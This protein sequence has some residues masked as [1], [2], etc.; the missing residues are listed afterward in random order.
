MYADFRDYADVGGAMEPMVPPGSRMATT[1]R[2]VAEAL[3]AERL[4]ELEARRRGLH[5]IGDTGITL[6]AA[7]R[8]RLI[9]V[10]VA[11]TREVGWLRNQTR[12][13]K[14][15]V[16]FF[17]RV[18]PAADPVAWRRRGMPAGPRR[19]ASVQ[20]PDVRAYLRWL[21]GLS[22]GRGG[23]LSQGSLRHHLSALSGVYEWAIS[24][25]HLPLGSN[26]V[27]AL[28]DKPQVPESETPLREPDEI[29]LLLE[30]ARLFD[31]DEIGV[32]GARARVLDCVHPLLAFFLYTGARED[33]VR[34][35]DVRDVHF[36]GPLGPW[37]EIR[38]ANKGRKRRRIQLLR[39]VPMCTHLEEILRAHIRT[40]DRLSGPL[41][42]ARDGKPFGDWRG[43]LD[44]VA[45]RAGYEAGQIRTR[46]F[47]TAYG[48]HR[49][50]CD[51]V[52]PNTVRLEMGHTSLEQLAETY[53]LTQ[54]RSERMG[55]E[56]DY[57][58]ERW[59]HRI[60][61]DRLERLQAPVPRGTVQPNAQRVSV[62]RQFLAAVQGM[63]PGEVKARTGVDDA[64]FYRLRTG[65]QQD[66][67]GKTLER[68]RAFLD[69][70]EE[71]SG[72]A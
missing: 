49:L 65:K 56:M 9:A 28:Q 15:A 45:A 67:K 11:R 69:A 33:E 71:R 53:A 61:P 5:L 50:T 48:T 38:G 27:A 10:R 31:P 58:L 2:D 35:A 29:A 32:P 16:R 51:D 59:L 46:Q 72:A 64:V 63:G 14:R 26:P 25:G 1:D 23:K 7:A 17:D 8:G 12:K 22:N 42:T 47:R 70:R 41:F 44:R 57:R 40:L 39:A 54:R 30:S 36:K 6:A 3:A 24:E 21:G 52:D 4:R 43:V 19:L 55:P 66:V 18:Q 13:L 20:P 60:D 68:M 37:V 62:V 34:R